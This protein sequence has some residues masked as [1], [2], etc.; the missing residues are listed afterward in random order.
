MKKLLLIAVLALGVVACDKNDLGEMDHSSISIVDT[1]VNAGMDIILPNFTDQLMADLANGTIKTVKKSNASTSKTDDYLYLRF[2]N[3][4]AN[5]YVLFTTDGITQDFCIP[6]DKSGTLPDRYY[7][8]VN[9]DGSQI[10]VEVASTGNVA[11]TI[12]GSFSSLFANDFTVAYK[13][14]HRYLI[15]G[16]GTADGSTITFTE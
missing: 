13:L 12:D 3:D 11:I 9:S 16:T 8:N 1:N 5:E 2:F 6:N 14:D 7:D 15:I 4:G 10:A